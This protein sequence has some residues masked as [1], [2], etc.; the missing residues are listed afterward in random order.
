VSD[1]KRG[2][3]F[4]A[5]AYGLWGLMPLYW[6]LLRPS[7]AVEILAHRLVWSFVLV[8]AVLAV[9]RRLGTVRTLLH[10]RRAMWLLALAGIIITV[11]WGT[12]IYGV[13][14]GRVVES[15]LGYFMNPLV[16]VLL[17]VIVLRERL[18]V[19]QWT[20]VGVGGT[21]LV[22]LSLDY[23]RLPWIALILGFSFAAY[24]LVKKTLGFPAAE[25]LF[26]ETAAMLLPAVAY[27][28]FLQSTGDSTFATTSW[29]HALLLAGAGLVTAIP[30]LFFAGAANRLPMTALGM[31]QYIAP[32]LQFLIGV[33]VFH[34][35]MPVA[36][37]LGFS[38]VWAAL[39]IFTADA[40]RHARRQVRQPIADVA[41]TSGTV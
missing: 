11:N 1:L 37:W 35:A 22:V 38:L 5:A 6:K 25:G 14:S 4:A 24:G 39:V 3:L 30:L 16:T 20:A 21:A 29:S 32:S 9:T 10:R 12:Y 27:L 33:I 7:G 2:Y 36:R 26:A 28:V 40:V 18:R 34:E 19:A 13:N 31:T 17:G 15:A 8:A 41:L 23:G